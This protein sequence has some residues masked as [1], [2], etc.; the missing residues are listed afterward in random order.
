MKTDADVIAVIDAAFSSLEKPTHFTKFDHCGECKEYD[1]LLRSRDRET[2][3]IDDVGNV[4]ADPFCFCLPEGIGYYMP[5]LARLA[6]A[7]PTYNFG[8]YGDQ[9]IFH[10]YSGAK[11]NSFLKFCNAKQR[12]AVAALFAHVVETRT[13]LIERTAN[14]DDFLRAHEVWFNA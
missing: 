11:H 5:T 14:D 1:D 4:G 2:L 3:R 9:L 13:G 8:W 7:E 6:L 12:K 10:L